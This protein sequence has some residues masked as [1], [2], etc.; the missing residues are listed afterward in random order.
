MFV[1]LLSPF[2]RHAIDT[3]RQTVDMAYE[4]EMFGFQ[5]PLQEGFYRLRNFTAGERAWHRFGAF[6]AFNLIAGSRWLTNFVVQRFVDHWLPTASQ[7]RDGNIGHFH[8]SHGSKI[9]SIEKR[10]VAGKSANCRPVFSPTLKFL[11]ARV[12]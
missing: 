11:A 12:L 8:D 1:L 10:Y 7:R 3:L 6:E 5:V 4:S 9:L 2:L